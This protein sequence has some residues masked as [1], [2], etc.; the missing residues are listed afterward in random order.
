MPDSPLCDRK[1][2]IAIM[3]SLDVGIIFV[4]ENNDIIFINKSAEKIR[5]MKS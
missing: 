4:D 5:Q 1:S 2:L 3:D